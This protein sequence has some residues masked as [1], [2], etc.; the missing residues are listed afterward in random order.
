MPHPSPTPA[1]QQLSALT[2]NGLG[3]GEEKWCSAG[4][5]FSSSQ[6]GLCGEMIST[7]RDNQLNPLLQVGGHQVS[8]LKA[9]S[10]RTL[11][12]KRQREQTGN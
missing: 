3:V 2:E 11:I 7:G 9:Q 6:P 5:N 4:K 10:V 8:G 12:Q 1:R